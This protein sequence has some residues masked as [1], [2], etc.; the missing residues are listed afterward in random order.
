MTSLIF[1]HLEWSLRDPTTSGG[2][3]SIKVAF[4]VLCSKP[5][6]IFI[7]PAINQAL[8]FSKNQLS[9]QIYW[10]FL[11]KWFFK[12]LG[13]EN[14]P[15]IIKEAQYPIGLSDKTINNLEIA[16]FGEKE[17]NTILYPGFQ[18]IAK[19]E[20]FDDVAKCFE[21]VSEVEKIHEER[22]RTLRE[23][24]ITGKVFKRDKEVIWKCNNCGYHHYGKEAPKICPSCLHPQEHFE[25]YCQ[26]Y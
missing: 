6:R 21:E 16:A 23:N 14:I 2:I 19:E 17:E 15:A 25:L 18:K 13:E 5:K 26:N 12:F 10:C 9:L 1:K 8:S 11:P 3:L 20:G 22:F 24:I 7:E 4:C